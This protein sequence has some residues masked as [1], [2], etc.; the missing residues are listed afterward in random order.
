MMKKFYTIIAATIFVLLFA[1]L[2]DVTTTAFAQG[3]PGF[4]GGDEGPPQVPIDGGI[5]VLLAA[6]GAYAIH[7]LRKGSKE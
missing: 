5:G 7:K 4:P 2:P 3:I 1:L 6:G